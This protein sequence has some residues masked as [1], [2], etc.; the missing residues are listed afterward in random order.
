MVRTAAHRG[1]QAAI[2]RFNVREASALQTILGIVGSG[3][4][5]SVARGALNAAAPRLLTSLETA[6]AAPINLARRLMTGGPTSPADALVKHL[7]TAQP[8]MPKAPMV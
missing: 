4:G 7:Q 6:G 2:D 8:M 3:V 1:M 5:G